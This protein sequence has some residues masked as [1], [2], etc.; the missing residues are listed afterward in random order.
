[1]TAECETER[2]EAVELFRGGGMRMFVRSRSRSAA[3][4]VSIAGTI[5]KSTSPQLGRELHGLVERGERL[6]L[7]DFAGVEHID[8]SAIA[9]L[10]DCLH[11]LWRRGG[12][13]AIFGTQPKVRA[14]FEIFM[15]N[16]VLRL[17]DSEPEALEACRL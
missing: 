3:T 17:C 1:M 11:H 4:V 5:N 9:T 7:I 15:L 13:M 16:G 10:L 14:W 2:F 6:L 8:S 12:Q